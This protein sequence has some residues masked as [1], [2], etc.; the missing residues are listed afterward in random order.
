MPPKVTTPLEGLKENFPEE[1][2]S[3]PTTAEEAFLAWSEPTG[4]AE[5]REMYNNFFQGI[6]EGEQVYSPSEPSQLTS[7]PQMIQTE[8]ERST[9]SSK[10]F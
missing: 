9:A 5:C 10:T 1:F 6:T 8:R 7:D 2:A 4:R 3:N